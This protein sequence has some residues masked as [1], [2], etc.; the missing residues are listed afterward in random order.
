VATASDRTATDS[1]NLLRVIPAKGGTVKTVVVFAGGDPVD[2]RYRTQVPSGAV[3]VAADSGLHH[4]QALGIP[5]DVV[6]GDLDSVDQARLAD[7]VAQGTQVERHPAEKDFT[8][9]EL[10]LQVAGRFGAT[11]VLVVGGAGGRLDHF[12]ANALLL[13]S[14][15][16]AHL[17]ITALVGDAR[18]TIVRGEAE[19]RGEP[20][21]LLT[22]LALGGV[23]RGVR[24]KGLRFPLVSED[25]LP[26]S[27]RGVSNEFVEPIAVVDLGE[28]V[29]LAVQPDGGAR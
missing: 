23:A 15:A 12:F 21:S 27:T 20:G 8:D 1:S 24:T 13:A 17:R 4:A 28:G 22:L 18:I 11:D 3:V 9:L 2:P 25:L 16:F 7:A 5:V 14:D 10:A 29:L 6:V 19:L 26:G